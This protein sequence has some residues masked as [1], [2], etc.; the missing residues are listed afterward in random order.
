M[1]GAMKPLGAK[2]LALSLV[3]S[4]LCSTGIR[5]M[6]MS[7]VVAQVSSSGR[8]LTVRFAPPAYTTS[9]L[10]AIDPSTGVSTQ[11]GVLPDSYSLSQGVSAID[12]A[13]H[14]LFVTG[15][16]RLVVVDTQTGAL[17]ANPAL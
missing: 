1:E 4:L 15:N 2:T 16:N 17:V 14:R 9:A 6:R 3:V 5:F 7:H 11:V 10:F 8:L 12:P 13:T